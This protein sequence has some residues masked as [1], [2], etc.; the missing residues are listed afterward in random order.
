MNLRELARC[1]RQL[2]RSLWSCLPVPKPQKIVDLAFPPAMILRRERI[3]TGIDADVANIELRTLDKVRYLICGS[4]AEAA[5]RN[6][7]RGAPSLQL[8]RFRST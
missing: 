2:R 6:C 8:S 5:C 7:H 1:A 4:S 3:D